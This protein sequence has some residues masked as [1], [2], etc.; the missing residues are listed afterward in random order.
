[1]KCSTFILIILLSLLF[2]PYSSLTIRTTTKVQLATEESKD[3]Q[4]MSGV[5]RD[6]VQRKALH[7]VHSGPNPISNSIPQ[8]KLK[9]DK[10]TNP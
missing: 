8:Q 2:L 10:E 4:Q 1:M 6:H 9:P 3:H 7:E 5:D